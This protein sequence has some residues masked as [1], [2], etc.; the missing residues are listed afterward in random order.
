MSKP[1]R[2]SMEEYLRLEVGSLVLARYD[3]DQ[4]IYRA[5]VEAVRK[6][7]R[8]RKVKVRFSDYGNSS[9]LGLDNL[10]L[11]ESR[12]EVLKPQAVSCRL[13]SY[14]KRQCTEEEMEE[15]S[16]IM[17]SLGALSMKVHKVMPEEAE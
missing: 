9:Q 1:A 2:L 10:Y 7:E 17:K 16:K 11:W 5:K 14:C 15:F 12:Y 13:K 3:V 4:E 8:D 6:E